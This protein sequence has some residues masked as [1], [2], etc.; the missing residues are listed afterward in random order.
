MIQG[1]EAVKTADGEVFRKSDG[2]EVVEEG[3][4]ISK[5]TIKTV[6][7]KYII[8][9]AETDYGDFVWFLFK[10]NE[11]VFPKVSNVDTTRIFYL[12]TAV[13]YDGVIPI[14]NGYNKYLSDLLETDRHHTSRFLKML[15]DQNIITEKDKSFLI[16]KN[17]FVRGKI[18]K[19]G[20]IKRKAVR[21]N[22][23]S[24][25]DLYKSNLSNSYLCWLFRFLP[26]INYKYNAICSNPWEIDVNKIETTPI[27]Y[28]LKL[29]EPECQTRRIIQ[30]LFAMRLNNEKIIT[31]Y[32]TPTFHK[33]LIVVNPKICYSGKNY[34]DAQFDDLFK[35]VQ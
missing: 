32:E 12:S 4:F 1:E 18:S 25:K 15:I 5:R 13:N 7:K 30:H 8:K 3:S 23:Q 6:A 14:K 9:T 31:Y 21:I 34:H 35:D 16:N 29:Y 10:Q 11:L 28:I 24:I 22:T 26:Y 2:T 19:G 17:I 33:K 27:E 20:P